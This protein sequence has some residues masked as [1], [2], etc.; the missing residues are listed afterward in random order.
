[1]VGDP[2]ADMIVRIKNAGTAGNELVSIPFSNLKFEVANVLKNEGYIKSVEVIGK[3]KAPSS[4]KLE[5]G[6]SYLEKPA[7]SSELRRPRV[8]GAERISKQS[9][10]IYIKKNELNALLKKKGLFVVS[11]TSGILSS[12]VALEK[13]LGG[14]I[15]FRI[16]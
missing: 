16:W 1:M 5:I 11:T 2:I 6:I 9:R 15:L 8:N 12:K 10:R 7:L 4:R 14:E 13:G 3:D